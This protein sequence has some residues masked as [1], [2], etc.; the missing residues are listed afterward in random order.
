MPP[1]RVACAWWSGSRPLP[2]ALLLG[3]VDPS[4]LRGHRFPPPREADA[5]VRSSEGQ[6]WVV[7]LEPYRRQLEATTLHRGAGPGLGALGRTGL[8]RAAALVLRKPVAVALRYSSLGGGMV[9]AAGD[10]PASSWLPPGLRAGDILV[11]RELPRRGERFGGILAQVSAELVLEATDGSADAL[12]DEHVWT[13]RPVRLRVGRTTRIDGRE[14]PGPLAGF[15]TVFAGLCV[16]A[17]ARGPGDVTL[18]VQDGSRKLDALLQARTYAG[19]GGRH[20]GSELTGKRLPL[21]YGYCRS[22]LPVLVDKARLIWQVHDGEYL[23][24]LDVRDRGVGLQFVRDVPTYEALEALSVAGE[25]VLAPDLP[26]GTYA[27]CRA[28]GFLRTAG[29][30]SELKIDVEGDGLHDGPRP[31]SGGRRFS[32]WGGFSAPGSQTHNR[33]AGGMLFRILTTRANVPV[34][35]FDLDRVAQFDREN[36]Y[37]LGLAVG[38]DETPTCREACA[39]IVESIAA[40]LVRNREGKLILRALDGPAIGVARPIPA[41]SLVPGGL[42]R[43]QLPWAAPWPTVRVQHA[44]R[45]AP[46]ALAELSAELPEATRAELA[47][48]FSYADQVDPELKALLPDRDPLVVDSLLVDTADAYAI[49]ARYLQFYGHQLLLRASV[50]GIGFRADPLET[51]SLTH[52]RYGLAQGRNLLVV[53]SA[54]RAGLNQTDL[55]LFG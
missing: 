37:R 31:F 45:W 4:R 54:V 18:S 2:I 35:E 42:Q 22:V 40:C 38:P 52:P 43:L 27:T 5:F 33:Y 16:Q 29:A 25:D 14:V 11:S 53:S 51:V 10:A 23:R 3:R 55:V 30:T 24:L 26:L 15:E 6:A 19:T 44:R 47:R 36:P 39:R 7:E 41:S 21:V 48:E 8:G 20:G 46:S 13:D 34:A 17:Y 12:L 49:A 28:E 50:L 32:A 1:R 9:T